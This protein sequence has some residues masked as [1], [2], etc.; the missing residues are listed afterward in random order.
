MCV[1]MTCMRNRIIRTTGIWKTRKHGKR[2]DQRGY[3]ISGLQSKG[4]HSAA[5][6]MGKNYVEE[7]RSRRRRRRRSWRRQMRKGPD[8]RFLL[9]ERLDEPMAGSVWCRSAN[10]SIIMCVFKFLCNNVS[11]ECL[12]IR[13]K[14]SQ[15]SILRASSLAQSTLS[16]RLPKGPFA[17]GAPQQTA[18]CPELPMR[19]AQVPRKQA[20]RRPHVEGRD[21]LRGRR[22]EGP[23]SCVAM[24]P[25][26]SLS[27]SLSPSLSLSL[28]LR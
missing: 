3:C 20:H 8:G 25:L 26:S 21:L 9:V 18:E 16:L 13:F 24:R 22:K 2:I 23:A 11:C 12:I 5:V 14:K 27:L 10:N 28:S 4:Y 19:C 1:N 6:A 15:R 7:R 17:D